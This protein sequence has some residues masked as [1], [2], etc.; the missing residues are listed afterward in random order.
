MDH[1]NRQNGVN[2][3]GPPHSGRET[4]TGG[5]AEVARQQ[6]HKPRKPI[7]HN[8]RSVFAVVL[9]VLIVWFIVSVGTNRNIDWHIV[10]QYLVAGA[11]LKGLLVTLE[12]SF[13]SEALALV[14]GLVIA[15]WGLSG[16]PV[17]RWINRV[18]IWFF[19][20][21]PLLVQLLVWGNFAILFSHLQIGI[22][23]THMH[24]VS[25]AT[26]SV[27]TA[28]VASVLGLGLHEGAFSAEI[29][30]AGI[31]SVP[32][33]QRDAGA[34]LGLSNGQIMHKVILPQALKMIIPNVGNQFVGLLKA[35]SLVSVIAGGDLLTTAEDIAG[36]NYA[37]LEL[38]FVATFWYLVLV[39]IT[40][41][42]QSRI[43]RRMSPGGQ[44]VR[45]NEF[46]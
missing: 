43:E 36:A 25:V 37:T 13:A 11:I 12:L 45:M 33:G 17:L 10:G 23:G 5:L 15:L 19:R 32:Q 3:S 31:E 24:L 22:P 28:F 14:T 39:S 6:A 26:N 20:G 2:T 35:S 18:W 9:L 8:G 29:F 44:I 7:R 27:I 42:V 46:A 4:A 1:P 34:S 38:L 30:R 16:N 40:T 41:M 21:V